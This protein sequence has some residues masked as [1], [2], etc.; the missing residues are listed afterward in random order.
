MFL[1][2]GTKDTTDVEG[3]CAQGQYCNY[4][5]VY[6]CQE[7]VC[8]RNWFAFFFIPVIPLGAQWYLRCPHCGRLTSINKEHAE[9]LLR[10]TN[11]PSPK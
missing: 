2:M 11:L 1:I 6:D 3:T 9:S 8:V 7:I 4:C 10:G 5:G